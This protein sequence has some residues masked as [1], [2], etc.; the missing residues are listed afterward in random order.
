MRHLPM[1]YAVVAVAA[2]AAMGLAACG[3]SSTTSTT[4][5]GTPVKG[6]TLKVVAAS[7]RIVE[8]TGTSFHI[9]ALG[10]RDFGLMLSPAYSVAEAQAPLGPSL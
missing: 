7:G 9:E 8:D 3:G 1:R 10:V 5:A 4:S 2:A 6:G